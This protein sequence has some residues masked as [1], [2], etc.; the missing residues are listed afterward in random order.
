M[1][2]SQESDVGSIKVHIPVMTIQLICILTYMI[3]H[4]CT[5]TFVAVHTVYGGADTKV[6]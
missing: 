1:I 5:H 4:I 6:Q 3:M 2:Y